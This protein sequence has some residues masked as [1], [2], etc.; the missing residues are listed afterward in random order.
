[1]TS[2]QPPPRC[3]YCREP[4]ADRKLVGR[5][6]V[7]CSDLHRSADRRRR[8][9]AADPDLA[10]R[11]F[12]LTIDQAIA[13]CGHS[14]QWLVDQV[15]MAGQSISAAT[16][17]GW[18]SGTS[19]PY[20]TE[21]TR[22]V[23]LSAER[24]V[25]MPTGYLLAALER[26]A[27]AGG[28]HG[29]PEPLPPRPRRPLSEPEELK[30]TLEADGFTNR[31]AIA[32]VEARDSL[33]IAADRRPARGHSAYRLCALRPG[34]RK[35]VI[36]MTVDHRNPVTLGA[37]GYCRLGRQR[38]IRIRR[39]SRYSVLATEFELDRELDAY[40]PYDL[41]FDTVCQPVPADRRLPMPGW[42]LAIDD[43][44]CRFQQQRLSFAG[45]RP[46]EVWSGEWRQSS[47]RM[48]KPEA[49]EPLTSADGTFEVVLINPPVRRPSLRWRWPGAMEAGLGT[50]GAGPMTPMYATASRSGAP[51]PVVSIGDT[52]RDSRSTTAPAWGGVR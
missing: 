22:N 20:L 5:P 41:E 38:P 23:L 3:P 42:F 11:E 9:A 8:Q 6:K 1:M 36:V 37:V 14:A 27:A 40:E 31:G 35:Y 47:G 21:E 39:N 50:G 25:P 15:G 24:F 7:Y 30:L 45:E 12:A 48:P 17:S 18:R 43:P 26:T 51:A 44:A 4:L 49:E 19:L 29:W 28:R 16:L 46:K 32:V 34:V 33:T 2:P 13:D 10:T 52:G